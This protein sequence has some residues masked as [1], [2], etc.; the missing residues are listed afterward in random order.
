MRLWAR[1]S[2]CV[3]ASSSIGGRAGNAGE[4]FEEEGKRGDECRAKYTYA[5]YCRL[6]SL[7]Q[8]AAKEGCCVGWTNRRLCLG[9]SDRT[10]SDWLTDVK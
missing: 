7:S 9:C 2:S 3:A 5:G 8:V 1:S 4:L 6:L 10:G